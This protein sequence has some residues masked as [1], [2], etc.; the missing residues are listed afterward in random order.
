MVIELTWK[1]FTLGG[2]EVSVPA[3]S[4]SLPVPTSDKSLYCPCWTLHLSVI[5]NV[6]FQSLQRY[7]STGSPPSKLPHCWGT[8]VIDSGSRFEVFMPF[9][10]FHPLKMFRLENTSP[11]WKC[12]Y[13][14]D[15]E[16][17]IL[18]RYLHLIAMSLYEEIWQG[19]C[20]MLYRAFIFSAGSFRIKILS[21]YML[22]LVASFCSVLMSWK[23]NLIIILKKKFIEV[24]NNIYC[25]YFHKHAQILT[26]LASRNVSSCISRSTLVS[27]SYRRLPSKVSFEKELY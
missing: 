18:W 5:I 6:C 19:I 9:I 15:A 22:V 17:L 2:W 27:D 13:F 14:L 11:L 4:Q 26:W 10:D 1:A 23:K 20:H 16:G 8:S 7:P 21:I 12:A 25:A 24:E 3:T